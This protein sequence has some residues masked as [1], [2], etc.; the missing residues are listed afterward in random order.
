M[1]TDHKASQAPQSART[2]QGV[3]PAAIISR[4]RNSSSQAR[5]NSDPGSGA[6]PRTAARNEGVKYRTWLGWGWVGVGG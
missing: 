6:W 2:W 4:K 3:P 5:Q 1:P